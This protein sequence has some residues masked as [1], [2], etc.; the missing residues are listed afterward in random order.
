MRA[1]V[2]SLIAVTAVVLLLTSGGCTPAS[3]TGAQ[4]DPPAVSTAT[5]SIDSFKGTIIFD[6]GHGEIF[7]AEDTS[8]LGTVSSHRPYAGSGLQ[9]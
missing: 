2:R 5:A 9:G 6:T 1:L 8:E 4:V 3:R 7:G